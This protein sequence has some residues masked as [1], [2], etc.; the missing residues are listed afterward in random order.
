MVEPDLVAI[1]KEAKEWGFPAILLLLILFRLDRTLFPLLKEYIESHSDMA[2]ALKTH[3][4]SISSLNNQVKATSKDVQDS[5]SE[6]SSAI[7]EGRQD[8]MSEFEKLNDLVARV[9]TTS[10]ATM[11]DSK[12]TLKLTREIHKHLK[13]VQKER[14]SD[15]NNSEGI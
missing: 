4:E 1:F 12:Q 6:L 10:K 15:E 2:N 14:M 13:A 5:N 7:Q 8:S 11:E 3:S 9:E